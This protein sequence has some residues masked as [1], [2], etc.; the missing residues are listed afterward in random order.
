MSWGVGRRRGSDPAWL[1]LWC[2]PTG[3]ALIRPLAWDPP[4][5]AG[6]AL[7]RHEENRK[8]DARDSQLK[9]TAVWTGT[10]GKVVRNG[11]PAA[12]ALVPYLLHEEEG[13]AG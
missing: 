8:S 5:A 6:V 13:P 7:K 4:C 10:A 9:T 3:A 2:R 12:S 11:S 1:W